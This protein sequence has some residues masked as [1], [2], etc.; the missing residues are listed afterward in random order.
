LR[1]RQVS[2]DRP[3]AVLSSSERLRHGC[4]AIAAAMDSVGDDLYLTF[5]YD[6]YGAYTLESHNLDRAA[7]M[8]T[9]D[10]LEEYPVPGQRLFVVQ[11]FAPHADDD[12]SSR[13]RVCPECIRIAEAIPRKSSIRLWDAA[14]LRDIANDAF[15][16]DSESMRSFV[17]VLRSGMPPSA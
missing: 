15:M 1:R 9:W 7:A 6:N 17:S 14:S 5:T 16:N 13:A 11:Q 10:I 4:E 12:G 2:Q 3:A 8:R